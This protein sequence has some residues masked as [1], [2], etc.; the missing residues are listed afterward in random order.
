MLTTVQKTEKVFLG[1]LSVALFVLMWNVYSNEPLVST[2]VASAES[3]DDTSEPSSSSKSEEDDTSENKDDEK[4]DSEDDISETDEASEPS[5]KTE[6]SQKSTAN[7]TLKTPVKKTIAAPAQEDSESSVQDEASASS[8]DE[9][10][11]TV[12]TDEAS[13][14]SETIPIPILSVPTTTTVKQDSK[15]FMMIPVEIESEVTLDTEGNV[16]QVRKS[17]V[18]WL[19]EFFSL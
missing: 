9:D 14:K 3:Q 19:K 18:N 17:F 1:L 4:E 11:E 6:I 2:D 13:E 16:I 7:A 10:S 8:K 12:E 15:L 5:V